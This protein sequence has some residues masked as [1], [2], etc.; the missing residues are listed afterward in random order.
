MTEMPQP[1][2][3][4]SQSPQVG[5]PTQESGRKPFDFPGLLQVPLRRNFLT[6]A[7]ILF[8]KIHIVDRLP[9]KRTESVRMASALLGKL[10]SDT[11][12]TY[13]V[14]CAT[15]DTV[16]VDES[17]IHTTDCKERVTLASTMPK[18]MTEPTK[19]WKCRTQVIAATKT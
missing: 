5:S 15:L 3:L 10:L 2:I 8:W 18:T 12:G 17:G 9:T 7:L 19:I 4:C 1:Q 6:H 13:E 16:T 11:P 14:I